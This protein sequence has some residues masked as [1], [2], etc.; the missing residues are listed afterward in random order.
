MIR[1]REFLALL[2]SL[3]FVLGYLAV[4]LC[5]GW[6]CASRGAVSA[7]VLTDVVVIA[8]CGAHYFH[9]VRP[10]DLS[11]RAGLARVSAGTRLAFGAGL[12]VIWMV[13]QASVAVAGAYVRDPLMEAY[14]A[15]AASGSAGA[16]L[17]LS[18]VLAP[19]SEELLHRGTVMACLRDR[20]GPLPGIVLSSFVF[21]A[22]HGTFTHLY[23]AF[24]FGIVLGILY[25]TT[26]NL[27]Y[28]VACHS[29]CNFVSM[30]ISGTG[31]TVS[32]ATVAGL[33][34]LNVLFVIAVV[35]RLVELQ[36]AY[37][38]TRAGTGMAGGNVKLMF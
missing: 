12:I 26:R 29:A 8:L 14:N 5:A 37:R 38:R 3:A 21:A 13:L 11:V 15:K 33:A 16:G 7:T 9:S 27:A 31:L 10:D 1:R 2:K 28:C 34:A 22:L 19:V 35:E 30:V 25:E 4:G 24:F 18:L 36:D 6:A 32:A 20:Y 17:L 23:T